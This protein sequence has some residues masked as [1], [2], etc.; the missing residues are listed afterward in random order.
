[1]RVTQTVAHTGEVG[2]VVECLLAV[3][4][5]QGKKLS[6]SLEVWDLTDLR[7]QPEGSG[8]RGQLGWSWFF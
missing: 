7:G 5:V 6:V 8:S 4:M 2:G 1:M 3:R